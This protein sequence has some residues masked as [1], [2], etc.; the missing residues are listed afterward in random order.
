MRRLALAATLILCPSLLAAQGGEALLR[1]ISSAHRGNW[2]TTLTFVQRTTWPGG[3]KA[4]ETWYETMERPGKL[5]LD[6]ERRDS[7]VGGA[8]F[9]NDSI[10]QWGVGGVPSGQPRALVHPLMVLLHDIHVGQIEASIEKLRGLRFDL[11][12]S[13]TATWEGKSVAVV[14]ALAGDTTSAQ[15]WVD[16]ERLVVVRIIQPLANGAR[17]DTQI[18]K[19]SEG[20]PGLVEREI[21]FFTNG[22]HDMKE[23]YVWIKTGVTLDPSIFLP[24]NTATP[25]WVAEYKRQR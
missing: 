11:T 9:R 14:G 8:L 23:E 15:F 1:Q 21:N 16:P 22:T 7:M 20:G 25:A 6:F 2:W 17:R 24:G 3:T 18:G 13:S 10:Y 19:F 12:K 4:E 5:R